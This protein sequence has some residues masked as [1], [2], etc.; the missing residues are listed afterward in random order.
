ME[1]SWYKDYQSQ[2][3]QYGE[4][5]AVIW[6]AAINRSSIYDSGFDKL[7]TVGLFDTVSPT[8]QIQL[9]SIAKFDG[10]SFEKVSFHELLDIC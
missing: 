10:L 4:D 8:S 1:F 5:N 6:D 3:F 9:C 2:L 7:Y